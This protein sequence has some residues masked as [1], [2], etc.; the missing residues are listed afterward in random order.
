L[1]KINPA[2]HVGEKS[3][4]IIVATTGIHRCPLGY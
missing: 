2:E 3:K 4:F 1:A